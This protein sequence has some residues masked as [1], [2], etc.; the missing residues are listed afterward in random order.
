MISLAT[1][2]ILNVLDYRRVVARQNELFAVRGTLRA[3]TRRASD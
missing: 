2:T 1:K 3:S